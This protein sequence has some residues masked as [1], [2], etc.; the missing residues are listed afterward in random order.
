MKILVVSSL[1][2]PDTVG[3][4]EM[5]CRQ[6]VDA[7][8][9]RGHEVRVLTTAPRTP[10]ASAPHVLRSLKLTDMW[11]YY[12][13]GL[14]TPAAVRLKEAEAFQINAFNVHVMLGQLGE[15]EPDV[16]YLWMLV[17]IGGLGLLGCLHHLRTPW[18]WHLMDEV[19]SKLCTQ[20]YRVQPALA[21]EFSRQIRGTF[22]ACSG[23]LVETIERSGIELGSRVEVVPNWVVGGR[24]APRKGYSSVGRIKIASAAALLDRNYDKGIDLLIEAAGLLREEGVEGFTLD[25]FGKATDGYFMDLIRSRGV[26]D[27][28]TLMGPLDQADL[29]ERYS[30]YDV[31]GFP[32]RTKEPFAFAPLEAMTRGC[33]AVVNR[34]NGEAE[35]FVHGVDCLKV[36]RS[37]RGFAT[38]FRQ[39]IEGT[40]PLESIARRG[41]AVV[42]R[43]FQL[44]A[45]AP[46]IEHA[47]NEAARRDRSGAGT[48]ADAY[49]MAV[50]AEKLTYLFMQDATACA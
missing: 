2:P 28:V 41:Q 35:W 43:D 30:E 14:S 50:L 44:D 18:V 6:A 17:G 3:G 4:Y 45:I 21:A 29:I 13:D 42:W 39:L 47:L 32:G 16:V 24:P 26:G 49:R 19:P 27:A 34:A 12:S 31:F 22:L 7:L 33:A 46:R 11:D 1:Y 25:L 37:A 5:G 8:I 48:A 23:Q 10:C 36:E 20:F 40:V 9:A 38:A 15:F